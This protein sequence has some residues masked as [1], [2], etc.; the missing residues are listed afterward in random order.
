MI[1]LRHPHHHLTTPGHWSQFSSLFWAHTLRMFSIS[2]VLVL[3]AIYLQG[4]GFTFRQTLLFFLLQGVFWL[5]LIYPAMRLIA[6][7]G[8]NRAMAV[9]SV[10]VVGYLFTLLTI[11]RF[12]LP[13]WLPAFFW[14]AMVAP[15][16]F[17]LRLSFSKAVNRRN[18]GRQVGLVAAVVL[19]AMGVAPAIGGILATSVGI[20]IVYAIAI[21]LTIL[22]Y[23]PLLGRGTRFVPTRPK[24]SIARARKILPDLVANGSYTVEDLISTSAW[25]LLIFLVI[26]SYAGVGI[27]SS[28]IV[29]SA[30]II[31]LVIGRREEVKGTKGYIREGSWL[32]GIGNLLRLAAVNTGFVF[33]SNFLVGAGHAMIETPFTTRYYKH[34][35]EGR[36]MEYVFWMQIASATGWILMAGVL[37]LLALWLPPRE[38]LIVGIAASVPASLGITKMR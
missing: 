17:S 26:P 28:V 23:A 25:P 3:I 16:W 9:G 29:I 30:M 33:S 20:E 5:A 21:G 8:P 7:I 18:A 22:A 34:A 32:Y 31:S 19:G 15:Y 4:V 37:C 24:L 35:D 27:M 13:L 1:G 6:R 14:G 38:A 10:F 36:R 12:N 2:L 11:E